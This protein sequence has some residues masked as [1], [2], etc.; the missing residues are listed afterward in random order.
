MVERREIE[1]DIFTPAFC[2][3]LF[4]PFPPF[5]FFLLFF[6]TYIQPLH[7]TVFVPRFSFSSFSCPQK[8]LF[9][10]FFSH[11]CFSSLSLHCLSSLLCCQPQ[12][13][14]PSSFHIHTCWASPILHGY[15]Y[16]LAML[17]VYYCLIYRDIFSI[18]QAHTH[19]SGLTFFC[20]SPEDTH[21]YHNTYYIFSTHGSYTLS[22][23]LPLFVICY[24]LLIHMLLLSSTNMPRYCTCPLSYYHEDIIYIYRFTEWFTIIAA[25]TLHARV[26]STPALP[27]L[28]PL[29]FRCC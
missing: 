6:F 14:P 7:Y 18:L 8:V 3:L 16:M 5:I 19:T 4:P 23:P 15:G 10:L 24:I 29:A 9:I 1:G 12:G 13:P 27:C 25:L 2:F 22:L 20:S 28:P 26:F 11:F 17:S 21:T